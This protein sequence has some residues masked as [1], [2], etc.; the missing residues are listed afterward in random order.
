M[1]KYRISIIVPVYNQTSTI[2]NT[3]E[4]V[5][6]ALE[7]CDEAIFIDDCSTDDSFLN[8]QRLC[9]GY[10]N[11]HCYKND[12]N[13]GHIYTLNRAVKISSYEY[14]TVIGGDDLLSN[15]FC[16]SIKNTITSDD[17]F[18]FPPIITF[19]SDN[20]VN[21]STNDEVKRNYSISKFDIG[22][23]W[24][25][26]KGEKYGII[27]ATIKR[28]TLVNLGLFSTDSIVEDYNLFL[29][30]SNLKNSL[31]LVPSLPSFYR[32]NK[33]SISSKT[34]LMFKEDTKLLYKHF[35][36]SLFI[37]LYLKRSLSFLWFL[38]NKRLIK[39]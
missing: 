8:L 10:N 28:E 38:Y 34:W 4:S 18:I 17:D 2:R 20:E 35:N 32:I 26:Y 11:L 23:G 14:I 39:K 25:K 29:S 5:I 30:A 12:R 22:W 27:G 36:F 13:M 3:V 9:E 24:G 37:I 6:K 15:G 7:P 16:H 33:N 19:E 1:V 21:L 31:R